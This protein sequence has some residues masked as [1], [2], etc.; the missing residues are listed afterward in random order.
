MGPIHSTDLRT[1]CSF[2]V[3]IV[4]VVWDTALFPSKMPFLMQHIKR[5]ALNIYTFA[6]YVCECVY[7]CA[8]THTHTH[9]LLSLVKA[10]LA[11]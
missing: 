8:H 6:L 5:F 7:A 2:Y 4:N 1:A 9:G 10:A 11:F 3:V